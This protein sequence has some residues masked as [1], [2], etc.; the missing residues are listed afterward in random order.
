MIK[1]QS[2]LV[3]ILLFLFPLT[4]SSVSE[5]PSGLYYEI[6]PAGEAVILGFHNVGSVMTVPPEIDGAPVRA[7]APQACRGNAAITELRLPESL[8]EIGEAAFADCPNLLLVTMNGGVTIGP[9]AFDGC[10]ALLSVALPETLDEIG[11]GAFRGCHVLGRV[12]IPSSVT[13]IGVDAFAGC[14]RVRF[15]VSRNPYAAAYAEENG[16]PTSFVGTWGFTCLM[17][18]A[19]TLLLGGAL[20]IGLRILQK[21]KRRSGAAAATGGQK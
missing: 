17:I 11:D 18:A 4:V 6:T 16:I 10:R 5:T 21:K 2:F 13:R 15:D 7:I 12:A 3:L 9:A 1:K 14:D 8:R 20:W 19:A